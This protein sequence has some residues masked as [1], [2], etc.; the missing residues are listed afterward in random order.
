MRSTYAV[1]LSLIES[2]PMHAED[3]RRAALRAIREARKAEAARASRR[4][5]AALILFVLAFVAGCILMP[6]PIL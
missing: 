6:S 5:W 1:H 3:R 4:V 2:I